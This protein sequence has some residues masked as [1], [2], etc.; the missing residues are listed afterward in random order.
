MNILKTHSLLGEGLAWLNQRERVIGFD[1]LSRNAYLIDPAADWALTVI[2]LPFRGSC[3]METPDGGVV[4]A[5]DHGLYHTRDFSNFDVLVHHEFADDMRMNDGRADPEGRFW[6][7]SMAMNADRPDGQVFCFDPATGSSRSVFEGLTIPNAICFDAR[8]R[9][10]YLADSAKK[11]INRFDYNDPEPE[12]EPF[13][14][15]SSAA[16]IP[17]GAVVD[18]DGCLWNAQWGASRVARYSP[19]GEL[20]NTIDVA[21]S[22]VTCPLLVAGH[23][24]VTSARIGLSEAVLSRQPDAGDIFI[25]PL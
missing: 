2:D 13:I 23:L 15:L 9:R 3:A 8:R 11:V 25:I 24:V 21:A 12:L 18:D 20:L 5:G 19:L 6:Y 10:G 14:D 17:D 16:G 7:S 22:Q 4:I 1:I